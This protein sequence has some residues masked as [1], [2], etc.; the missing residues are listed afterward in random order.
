MGDR[1]DAP[2]SPGPMRLHKIRPFE[3]CPAVQKYKREEKVGEG[4]FGS[5][6]GCTAL[7]ERRS[8]C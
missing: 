1:I 5:V 4:T 6:N 2:M 3:R 7:S 8:G